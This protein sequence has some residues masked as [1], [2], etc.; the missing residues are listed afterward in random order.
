M[1]DYDNTSSFMHNVNYCPAVHLPVAT[2]VNPELHFRGL[3]T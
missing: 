3:A 2:I 1:S